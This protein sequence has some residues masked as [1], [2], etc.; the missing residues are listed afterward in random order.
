MFPAEDWPARRVHD[1]KDLPRDEHADTFSDGRELDGA[2]AASEIGHSEQSAVN[3]GTM[4]MSAVMLWAVLAVL[5][6]AY[7]AAATW[8]W[9]RPVLA[10]WG[11][12]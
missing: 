12:L 5:A 11:W 8:E 6:C 2:H 9:L 1:A 4:A 10:G 7:F 3:R